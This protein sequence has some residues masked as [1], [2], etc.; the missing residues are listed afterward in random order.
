MLVTEHT[1]VVPDILINH[2]YT[3]KTMEWIETLTKI[4]AFIIKHHVF[5]G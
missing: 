3:L 5:T 4:N 2:N 1:S